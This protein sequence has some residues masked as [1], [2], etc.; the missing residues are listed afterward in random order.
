MDLQIQ[1][2]YKVKHFVLFS[3]LPRFIDQFIKFDAVLAFVDLK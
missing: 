3:F 1:L 2:P